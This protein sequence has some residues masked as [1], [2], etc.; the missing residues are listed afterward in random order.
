MIHRRSQDFVWGC[1]FPHEKSDDLVLVVT[2]FYI[3]IC[4]IYSHQLPFFIS[5]AG[6]HFTKFSPIVASFHK[7]YL[8]KFFVALGACNCTP[9]HPLAT[10]MV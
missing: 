8:E 3:V 4:I 5:S 7:K 6:V 9:L 10:P 1:T 2:L